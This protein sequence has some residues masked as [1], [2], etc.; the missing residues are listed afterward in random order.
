MKNSHFA[1]SVTQNNANAQ[2]KMPERT[3]ATQ[4]IN[5]KTPSARKQRHILY[6]Q[7]E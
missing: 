3:R 2:A 1:Y 7:L 5:R 6:Y 4:T